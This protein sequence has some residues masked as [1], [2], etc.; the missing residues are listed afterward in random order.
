MAHIRGVDGIIIRSLGAAAD[1]GLICVVVRIVAVM[2]VIMLTRAMMWVT[3]WMRVWMM[4]LRVTVRSLIR[5]CDWMIVIVV[6]SPIDGVRFHCRNPQT[7]K[8]CPET[9]QKIRSILYLWKTH[10]PTVR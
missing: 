4:W 1:A 3:V 2:I 9:V 10:R 8:S 5:M 6:V 7:N